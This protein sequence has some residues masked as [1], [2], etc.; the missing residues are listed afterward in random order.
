MPS[1]VLIELF[2]AAILL[3]NIVLKVE[4]TE[5]HSTF[6]NDLIFITFDFPKPTIEKSG[7]YHQITMKDLH[8]PGNTGLPELPVQTAKILLPYNM[9]I[10]GVKVFKGSKITIPGSYTIKPAQRPYPISYRGQILATLPDE[11]IYNSYQPFPKTI[12]SDIST[13][14]KKGYRILLVNLHPVEYIPK[15]GR[16]SYYENIG[17]KIRVKPATNV[18][19]DHQFLR[20]LPADEKDVLRIVD[21]PEVIETYPMERKVSR[22][23]YRSGRLP[24]VTNP[25]S[26]SSNSAGQGGV[27]QPQHRQIKYAHG[28]ILVKFKPDVIN[29]PTDGRVAVL[30]KIAIRSRAIENLN[31]KCGVTRMERV[32]RTACKKSQVRRLQTGQVITLPNLYDI[33][34]LTIPEDADILSIIKK[35][36]KD[37][38]VIYAEPNYYATLYLT[39]NDTSF[40]SQWGLHNTGQTGGTADADIDAPEAWDIH[41]G[42]GVTIAVIDTGVDWDHPDLANNIW[43]NSG[44]ISGNGIDDDGNGY[45][46]DTRGWD[47]ADNDNNPMDYHGHGTHVAGI[48]S[49][50]TNNSQGVA[51]VGWANKIM[52][53]KMFPSATDDAIGNAIKYAVDNG[54]RVLSNSWGYTS[55][56]VFP[57]VVKDAIDYA[58]SSGSL[59]IFAAGNDNSSSLY[60]P[61]AYDK[62]IGVA[63]TTHN[64]TKSSFSNYGDWVDVSAPGSSIYSTLWND[65]YTYMSGTSMACPF[66]SG[67]AGL[68]FSLYPAWTNTL[69]RQR[70][71][72]TTDDIDALNPGYEGKLG[73]GRINAYTAIFHSP[74]PAGNITLD[75][76][77][78]IPGDIIQITVTDSDLNTGATTIEQYTGIATLTTT[79]GDLE[80][81]ITMKETGSNTSIFKGTISVVCATSPT[82]QNG[83]IEIVSSGEIMTATYHDADDGTGN[84][85]I[86][87]ATATLIYSLSIS[88]DDFEFY[89]TKDEVPNLDI[90]DGTNAWPDEE[91]PDK[92]GEVKSYINVAS[93]IVDTV[94]VFVD[95]TH[96]WRGDISL[97]LISP[98]GNTYTLKA[99][100]A[101]DSA[102]NIFA[103]DTTGTTFQGEDA[104]GTWTLW[105]RDWW[106]EDTGALNLWRMR[107]TSKTLGFG[108]LG[109]GQIIQSSSTTRFKVTN[110]G[111]IAEDF[112]LNLTNP[113][114]WTAGSSAGDEVYVLKGLF[115]G[116][117]DSPTGMHFV[118]D[119]VIDTSV[120]PAS[121]TKFGDL[122][123]PANGA[124]VPVNASRYLWFQFQAPTSTTVTTQQGITV[125][126]SAQ[127]P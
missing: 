17:I 11:R 110:N 33:Y 30:G 21:N 86:V 69:V 85:A 123:M 36:E 66:V 50:V 102:D 16:I 87:H 8:S 101:G 109:L 108:Q 105:V 62:V 20:G 91:N 25:Q 32:F 70:I 112:T 118:W 93:L 90:P 81:N 71:E 34:K 114:T 55:P 7:E 27:E 13:Q 15:A 68:L 26:D 63:S 45:I 22:K 116:S 122:A 52:P 124:S 113:A 120:Q 75:K 89:Y 100:E 78:Y 51:G 61:G 1:K 60:Y 126:I 125:T 42:S 98:T 54:A 40:S 72:N 4:A 23:A 59:V 94:D 119:D 31:H 79:G 5:K 64:D 103:T 84:P 48:I 111:N 3:G 77:K 76:N 6:T 49:A 117:G 92:A 97:D 12:Y 10:A 47:F 38:D 37:P 106:R 39:P 44:E 53:V 35:Y 73:T 88:V 67:L 24:S 57:N 58:D 96:T 83:V 14:D 127:L 41:T 29:L 18:I 80:S 43:S 115:V 95:I 28:E 19:S 104:K 121:S 107:I 9:E 2:V 99:K 82:Q 56:G 46:D 65:T 74:V